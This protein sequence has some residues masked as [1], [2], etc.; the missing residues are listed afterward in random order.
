MKERIGWKVHA[1]ALLC[2]STAVVLSLSSGAIAK[3]VASA[4]V[5]AS[6]TVAKWDVQLVQTIPAAPASIPSTTGGILKLHAGYLSHTFTGVVKITNNSQV[7]ALPPTPTISFTA[8]DGGPT[9]V[10]GTFTRTD[11]GTVLA[12]N[13]G[14]ATYDL[15]ITATGG[16]DGYITAYITCTANQED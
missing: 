4:T 13:G 7:A 11:G 2:V 6:A 15:K 16:S 9:G 10:T 1:L 3:Y 14:T 8:V 12:P 5:S